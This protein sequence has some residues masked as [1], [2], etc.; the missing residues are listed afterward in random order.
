MKNNNYEQVSLN[1]ELPDPEADSEHRKAMHEIEEIVE[2]YGRDSLTYLAIEGEKQYYVSNEIHGFIAFAVVKRIAICIGNPV[3]PP[4]KSQEML[5]EF[6]NYCRRE[7]MKICF[8]SVSEEFAQMAEIDGFVKALYG[9]EAVLGLETYDIECSKT[10]KLR[11]KVRRAERAGIVVVEYKPELLRDEELENKI[12]DVS[13]DWFEQKEEMMTFAFG[14]LNFDRPLG[15][16]YFVACDEEKNVSAVLM[17]SPYADRKGY[18]LDVMRRKQ[19]SVPGVMEYAIISAAMK[20]KDEGCLWVSLGLA[21]LSGL[22]EL[23]ER[24]NTLERLFYSVYQHGN[25]TYDFQSLYQYK[26]KFNP[27]FWENRYVIYEAGMNPLQVAH[28]LAKVRNVEKLYK[29]VIS[30]MLRFIKRMNR[31]LKIK[32]INSRRK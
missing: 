15:R 2:L 10:A 30:Y 14:D 26:L 25:T 17:F 31:K 12:H 32:S 6:R 3:C 19:E 23:G 24:R 22:E 27:T 4:G 20:M 21:P 16:R 8:S 28:V 11:Q 18:F 13:R 1:M 5:S 7:H 9:Q 29:K